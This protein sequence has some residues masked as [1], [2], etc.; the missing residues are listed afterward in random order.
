MHS[1]PQQ[2]SFSYKA[3]VS[4]EKRMQKSK[5]LI[6]KHPNYIPAFLESPLNDPNFTAFSIKTV[7]ERS[8]DATQLMTDIRRRLNLEPST[9]IFFFVN[10]RYKLTGDQQ[11]GE[12]YDRY[13]DEDGFLYIA[14][15]YQDV[16]G[17]NQ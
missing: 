12:V 8:K 16:M 15:T 2:V 9:A 11:I 7:I 4:L 10:N 14:C 1:R 3:E 5:S 13:M 6:K 17:H